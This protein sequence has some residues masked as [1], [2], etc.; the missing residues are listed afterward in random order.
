MHK[1]FKQKIDYNQITPDMDIGV[2][3]AD[4]TLEEISVSLCSKEELLH[5]SLKQIGL[6]SMKFDSHIDIDFKIK[7]AQLDNM[8]RFRNF[9]V[10]LS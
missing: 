9:E 8:K 6:Y 10:I 2:L 1:V 3:I 5:F 4:I 7:H